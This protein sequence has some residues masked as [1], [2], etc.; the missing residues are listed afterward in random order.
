MAGDLT[1]HSDDIADYNNQLRQGILEAYTGVFQ[2]VSQG[3]I[4]HWLY[5]VNEQTGMQNWTQVL[6]RSVDGLACLICH[7]LSPP[8]PHSLLV[9]APLLSLGASGCLCHRFH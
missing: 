2:G 7:F 4:N 6:D 5:T 8:Q 1:Y 3:K 9:N